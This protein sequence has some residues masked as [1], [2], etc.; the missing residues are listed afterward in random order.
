MGLD[1]KR[2]R[3]VY[4]WWG[5]HP[6]LFRGLDELVCL[7]RRQELH[8]R[9]VDALGLTGGETV[10]DLA[11]GHG[12]NFALLEGEIGPSG[13]LLA[14]DYS[15]EMV[16]AAHQRVRRQGWQNVEVLQGDA[17]RM[18]IGAGSLDGVLCSFGLSV[19]PDQRGAI[20]RVEAALGAD[21]RFVVLDGR[22]FRGPAR[23]LNPAIKPLFQ[24]T[25]NWRHPDANLVAELER[26]FDE[27]EVEEFNGG[28]LFIARASKSRTGDGPKP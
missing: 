21:G 1:L 18:E 2:G 25:S 3:R 7:G 5:R 22:T 28:S 24:Y 6:G 11:C 23:V 12:V 16:T 14:L 13:R 26:A 10:L 17:A 15:E 9:A 19:V 20:E 4:D 27:V 8:R